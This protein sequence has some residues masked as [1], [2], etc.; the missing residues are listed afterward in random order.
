MKYAAILLGAVFVVAASFFAARA[1]T[2]NSLTN[3]NSIFDAFEDDL[4]IHG[5][6]VIHTHNKDAA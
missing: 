1:I 2:A 3:H 6:T 4:T 5:L